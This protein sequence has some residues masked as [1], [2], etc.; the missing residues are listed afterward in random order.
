MSAFIVISTSD[1]LN[2]IV[3]GI[4]KCRPQNPSTLTHIA[5]GKICHREDALYYDHTYSVD[6]TNSSN[7]AEDLSSL[8]ANQM[9]QF[10]RA[11]ELQEELQ[12]FTLEN[13]IDA[14]NLG[15][16][17]MVYEALGEA[18]DKRS[19]TNCHITRILFSYDVSDPCNVVKQV[20]SPVLSNYLT[21]AQNSKYATKICYVDNQD[22]CCAAISTSKEKHNLMLPRM[23]ADL[24]MLISSGNSAYNVRNAIVNDQNIFSIGYAECMYYFDD[25][26]R[27]YEYA[28][29]A[30]MRNQILNYKNDENSLDY[31]QKPLGV[32][33]RVQRLYP[34][35]RDVP[36][37]ENI[38]S[39]I[40]S[41]SHD[42]KIDDI[43]RSLKE[44]II[45]MKEQA[46]EDAIAKDE[47]LTIEKRKESEDNGDENFEDI[48]V[49][50]NQD[51][52]NREYPDY[53]DR[54]IVY[55]QW[56]I[57]S[58][59]D[60]SFEEVSSCVYNRKQYY[61]LLDFIQKSKFK[62]Y[63][64]SLTSVPTSNNTDN[65][66]DSNNY[67]AH[68][69]N[70][71]GCNIFARFF[72]KASNQVLEDVIDETTSQESCVPISQS[73]LEQIRQIPTLQKEKEQYKALCDFEKKIESELEEYR[74]L[75]EEF[76]LTTHASSY[77]NLIDKKSLKKTQE[78]SSNIHFSSIIQNWFALEEGKQ[79]LQHLYETMQ[80]ECDYELEPY[81]YIHWDSP[82]PFVKKNIDIERL[83]QRLLRGSL[84][85]VNT[86][87]HRATKENLTSVYYY[88]DR[89]EWES[90]IANEL[91]KLP[92]DTMH[93]LST[94][95]ESK[96]AIFQILQWEEDIINGLT[97][98]YSNNLEN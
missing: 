25:V 33:Q 77:D 23:L 12:I 47:Q 59:A 61:T 38:S 88:F 19:E 67:N 76:K 4:V 30:E 22:R 27:Y 85:L 45:R 28:Y 6:S 79:D 97:D 21:C 43:I 89:E 44:Y 46:M 69:E 90:R 57:V 65:T 81:H 9:A 5:T 40:A 75:K 20:L 10:R 52:V 50:E 53:I 35:Y 24:M 91:I 14:E 83:S 93:Q 49:T 11:T 98:M 2:W 54:E 26:K 62:Q 55:N 58:S 56:L 94:H 60:D 1:K 37:S 32:S 71:S 86:E 41:K 64:L 70:H 84:P 34:I 16:C 87:T 29:N 66:I 63:L 68:L 80:S 18:I 92:I 78:E 42:K 13:P 48:L 7:S 51:R 73:I 3:D 39:E 96:Y 95:I 17:N 74:A 31:N 15:C 72:K 82:A 36:F 8:L